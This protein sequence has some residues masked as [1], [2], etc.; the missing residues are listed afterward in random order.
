L[1]LLFLGAVGAIALAAGPVTVLGRTWQI[2]TLFACIFAILLGTQIVQLGVFARAFAAS[3]LGEKD[4]W[5]EGARRR[6]TVEHGLV[7]GGLVLLAGLLTILVIFV[8]WAIGGFGAL[9]HEYA[10]AIGFTLLA[11]GTQVI[12]GSFFLALLTMRTTEPSR[13]SVVEHVPVA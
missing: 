1:L 12:L 3:H 4:P 11:L 10:T 2:H 13:A 6:L 9:S 7:V 8:N 5:V